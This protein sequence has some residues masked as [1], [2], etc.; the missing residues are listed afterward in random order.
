AGPAFASDAGAGGGVKSGSAMAKTYRL[1]V[2]ARFINFV[3][4]LM[5]RLGLGASYRYILTVRGERADTS[6]PL[7]S[8]YS[9]S[10]ATAGW[11]R[12]TDQPGGCETHGPPAKSRSVAV[13]TPRSSR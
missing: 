2:G 11:L 12:D 7:P 4:R 8:M 13:G 9:K 6:T 5:T 1:N 10:R 3:F